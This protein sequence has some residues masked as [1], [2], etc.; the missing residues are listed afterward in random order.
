[1][2]RRNFLKGMA[3]IVALPFILDGMKL[4]ALAGNKFNSELIQAFNQTDKV[5]VLIQLNGGNDGLNTVIPIDQYSLYQSLRSN[6]AI[7]E[8]VVLKLNEAMGLHPSMTGFKTLFDSGKM[9]L[10]NGVSYPNPN[11][12]HFRATDIWMTG[13]DYNQYLRSGITG[14][15]LDNQ[16]PDYPDILSDFKDPLA[17]QMSATVSLSFQ[18]PTQMMAI[19]IQDPET[20]YQL[21]NGTS[22]GTFDA[23]PD[24]RFGKQLDYIRQVQVSSQQYSSQIK[25][26][27]DKAKNQI[28][29]PTSNKLADQLKIVARLIAGGLQ[30]RIY[31]VNLGGFDTHS[32]QTGATDTSKGN[33]ANLLGALSDAVKSFMDDLKALGAEDRVIGMTFSEFGRRVASNASLGTDHG[34][35]LPVFVFGSKVN[36][37][38]FGNSPNLSD[39]DKGNLKMQFDFRQLYS[40]ILRQWFAL[41]NQSLNDVML[42]DYKQIPII[43]SPNMVDEQ[44][45]NSQTNKIICYPNPADTYTAFGLHTGSD[46]VPQILLYSENGNLVKEFSNFNSPSDNSEI[47]LNLSSVPSGSYMLK[48]L[49]GSTVQT[50]RINIIH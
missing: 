40:S 11:L 30:T 22:S 37:V 28:T 1:M 42:K 9:A 24:T 48:V 13:S 26:A 39:L 36:P 46:S 43:L 50:G 20:F 34:T 27:A 29:Y 21:V 41:D 12:S 49:N 18:G 14:R 33:H 8:N 31:M 16:F 44:F 15:Y 32:S 7:D 23:P 4:S 5:L 2:D 38:I 19:A 10:I 3:P 17:I 25:T 35:S 6:I 47:R 45:N